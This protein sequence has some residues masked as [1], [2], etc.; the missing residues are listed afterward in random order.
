MLTALH[1]VQQLPLTSAVPRKSSGSSVMSAPDGSGGSQE[2]AVIPGSAQQQVV[3]ME[4]LSDMVQSL[5]CKAMADRGGQQAPASGD[6][7]EH[8]GVA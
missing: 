3:L 5:V 4:D 7:G 2:A 1:G 8:S 6:S